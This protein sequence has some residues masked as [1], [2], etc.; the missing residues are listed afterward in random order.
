MVF[1]PTRYDVEVVAA[2]IECPVAAFFA[3]DDTLPGATPADAR[4]LKDGLTK[5][6]KVRL[7]T[8]FMFC[9]FDLTVLRVVL[10]PMGRQDRHRS[11]ISQGGSYSV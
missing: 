9:F 4:A 1:C 5:N 8:Q 7:C 6:A 10:P 11:H 3:G 2:N